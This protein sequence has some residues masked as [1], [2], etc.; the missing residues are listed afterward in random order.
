M[1]KRWREKEII[2]KNREQRQGVS[3]ITLANPN[4]IV[5]EQFRTIRTNIQFA[6][7]E[8]HI[9][10]IMFTSSG[11]W[12][13]KSTIVANVAAVMADLGLRV[14]VMD[15]DLR[16]P[17]VHKTFDINARDGLT[18]LLTNRELNMMKYVQYV[19]DANL[20]VLPAGPKPP[21]P[22]ELLSSKRMND[23][24]EEVENTF[25]LVI[26]DTPPIL[27]VTDAQVIGARA[28]GVVFVLR[29]NVSQ[30]RNVK[31]AKELL[32]AVKANVL[33]AVYNGAHGE[34]IN[35]YYGYG[36]RDEEADLD[37]DR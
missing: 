6:L 18:S 16:K 4:D 20:Y 26:I 21:N 12:E 9:K 31:K 3:L 35:S 19:P 36:Y 29:E 22:A 11:A 8:Q 30:I 27:L 25:D 5:S 7:E 34:A 23:I 28:H 13:G 1:F 32:D 24:L 33:G 17:T 10:S 15:C 37:L 2:R 14:L